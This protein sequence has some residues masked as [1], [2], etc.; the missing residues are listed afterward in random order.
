MLFIVAITKLQ[1]T[2]IT[3]FKMLLFVILLALLLCFSGRK[4]LIW[5]LKQFIFT[6]IVLGQK[7]TNVPG[8]V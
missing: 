5:S 2:K 6:K 1:I 4:N 8:V 3:N 7:K